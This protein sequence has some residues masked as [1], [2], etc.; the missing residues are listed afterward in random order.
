MGVI[1]SERKR[2]AEDSGQEFEDGAKRL[3][4]SSEKE[5]DGYDI[6]SQSISDYR[7]VE[8][9]EHELISNVLVTESDDIFLYSTGNEG[10]YNDCIEHLIIN[11][12]LATN[13]M[14]PCELT[15]FPR[16]DYAS[17]DIHHGCNYSNGTS[18]LKKNEEEA[19]RSEM[20]TCYDHGSPLEGM[21]LL[22]DDVGLGFG[23]HEDDSLEIVA[24]LVK[25]PGEGCE[26]WSDLGA[27]STGVSVPAEQAFIEENEVHDWLF[28]GSQRSPS[29]PDSLQG[30]CAGGDHLLVLNEPSMAHVLEGMA[31][32]T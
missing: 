28:G 26:I 21:D 4:R 23:V 18:D 3:R 22:F 5:I 20:G 2:P 27:C 29:G 7:N 8:G 11:G 6:D 12:D 16:D 30:C 25:R 14:S 19:G 32:G 15:E 9:A 24:E 17:S 31:A 13:T 1:I 10:V